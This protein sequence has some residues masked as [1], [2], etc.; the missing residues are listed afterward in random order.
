MAKKSN[1]ILPLLLG[2]GLLFFS[3][4]T[5][6]KYKASDGKMFS[7]KK[8]LDAY[9]SSLL[10]AKEQAAKEQASKNNSTPS[11]STSTSTSTSLSAIEKALKDIDA[12]EGMYA[13]GVYVSDVTMQFYNDG[14]K[15]AGL[16]PYQFP[17][18]YI[19]WAKFVNSTNEP[20]QIKIKSVSAILIDTANR[21]K[22]PLNEQYFIVP[23]HTETDW[24]PI[25][26]LTEKVV[27]DQKYYDQEHLFAT[28]RN[29]FPRWYN[30][31][32]P[33]TI[34][35]V[36]D[37]NITLGNEVLAKDVTYEVDTE[38]LSIPTKEFTPAFGFSEKS[39]GGYYLMKGGNIKE[40][41]KSSNRTDG[42]YEQWHNDS[43]IN[44]L[45]P[46]NNT[47][48]RTYLKI[49]RSTRHLGSK[50]LWGSYYNKPTRF[51]W[52]VRGLNRT[53]VADLPFSYEEYK[54]EQYP[55]RGAIYNSIFSSGT[56]NYMGIVYDE[57]NRIA[58]A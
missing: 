56:L 40:W 42:N 43:G 4:F 48:Y 1:K 51:F 10:A 20:V 58:Y 19:V 46:D 2:A 12:V 55:K 13:Q 16:G 36:Y 7:S 29:K 34:T 37:V 47:N 30:W 3:S 8:E 31:F 26:V 27:K 28:M 44:Y 53:S 22:L 17:Y 35:I 52:Y 33:A 38:F 5:S 49:L 39:K 24:L 32:F 45:D 14:Q 23:K 57:F 25:V 15:H 6:K 11:T 41:V 50:E 21:R 54:G 18:N 9:E